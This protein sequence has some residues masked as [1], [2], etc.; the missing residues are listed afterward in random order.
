MTRQLEPMGGLAIQSIRAF[1]KNEIWQPCSHL[2]A[3]KINLNRIYQKAFCHCFGHGLE[4]NLDQAPHKFVCLQGSGDIAAHNRQDQK[5][6]F[7]FFQ[8]RPRECHL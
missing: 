6:D 4:Y 2:Q 7:L 8:H 3:V 1:N 5:M